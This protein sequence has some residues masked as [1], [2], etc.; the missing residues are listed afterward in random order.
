MVSVKGI[1][2]YALL[3][4]VVTFG[5]KLWLLTAEEEHDSVLVL[6]ARGAMW[7]AD[8]TFC[9]A[10]AL[11]GAIFLSLYVFGLCLEACNHGV[12]RCSHMMCLVCCPCI[13]A[14]MDP[15]HQQLLKRMDRQTTSTVKYQ[16]VPSLDDYEQMTTTT[17]PPQD[18]NNSLARVLV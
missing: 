17:Q 4:I 14:C 1:L 11:T 5:L 18:S 9:I 2:V 3:Y 13:M 10:F 12:H 6:L 15:N 8:D 7:D 16:Q